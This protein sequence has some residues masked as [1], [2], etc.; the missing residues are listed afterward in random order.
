MDAAAERHRFW[1]EQ[2]LISGEDAEG[3]TAFLDRRP[4]AFTWTHPDREDRNP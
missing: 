2:V 3:I 4:P 1:Q